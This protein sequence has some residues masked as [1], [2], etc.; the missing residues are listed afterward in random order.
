MI[1]Q[2]TLNYLN[3]LKKAM[4]SLALEKIEEIY[5]LILE[6]LNRNSQIFIMGNGGS[7]ATASHFACDMN[8]GVKKGLKKAPRVICLNDN[9]PIMLAIANDISYNHIFMEQ[10]KN[11]LIPDDLVLGISCSGNSENV[12]RA[13]EYANKNDAKTIG[14]TGFKGGKLS[15]IAQTVFTVPINDT[16]KVEDIHMTLF[17]IIVQNI[18]KNSSSQKSTP[19]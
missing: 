11:F 6:A 14:I 17:H 19:K 10:L 16:Q 13:I 8:K 18:S 3:G 15:Q 1:K 9:V 5:Q 7:G 12:L 4:D 2:F